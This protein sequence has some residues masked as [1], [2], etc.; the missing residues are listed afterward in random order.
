MIAFEPLLTPLFTLVVLLTLLVAGLLDFLYYR[1]PNKF[2]YFLTAGFTVYLV[3]TGQW[4]L[5]K[6]FFLFLII[7]STGLVL[8]YFKIIGGGDVKI[9]AASFLWVGWDDAVTYLLLTTLIG[10][11]IGIYYLWSQEFMSKLT[12]TGRRYIQNRAFLQK[13]VTYF[14][15]QAATMEDEILRIQQQKM[16]PYGLAIVAAAIIIL[17]QKLG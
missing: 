11:I 3:L 13:T 12:I 2:F 9:F 16:I 6:N 14:I 10:A 17:G 15:P 5:W 7:L 1:L 8:F 4:H